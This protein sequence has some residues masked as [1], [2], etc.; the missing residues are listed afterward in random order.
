MISILAMENVMRDALQIIVFGT[1]I[2]VAYLLGA[3]SRF[4]HS[5][6]HHITYLNPVRLDQLTTLAESSLQAKRTNPPP[7]AAKEN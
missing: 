6:K 5:F 7:T 4:V 2:G 3:Q 1:V